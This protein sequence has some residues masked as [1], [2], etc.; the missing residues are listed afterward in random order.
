MNSRA[1]YPQSNERRAIRMNPWACIASGAFGACALALALAAAPEGAP[2]AGPT[3]RVSENEVIDLS[4]VNR[5]S[6]STGAEEKAVLTF[7]FEQDGQQ[8]NFA[9]MGPHA[10]AVWQRITGTAQNWTAAKK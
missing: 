7:F 4:K 6:R 3:V 1:S 8:S 5:I 10:D 9:I 2:P